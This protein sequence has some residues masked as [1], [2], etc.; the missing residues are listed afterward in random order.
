MGSPNAEAYL[1]SPAVVAAS[2]IAGKICGPD[3][4]DLKNLPGRNDLKFSIAINSPMTS[5]PPPP[6]PSSES[7]SESESKN[8]D[9]DLLLPGF[10]K[11]FSGPL[12]FAPQ[13]NLN[14]DGIYPGKYTYQDDIT[15]TKQSEVVMENYDPNFSKTVSKLREEYSL[16]FYDDSKTLTTSNDSKVG[17]SSSSNGNEERKGI[18]LI[19]GYNFGTGSSR[20]QAATALKYSGIPLVISGSFGDIFKRNSINNGLICLECPELIEDLTK[21]LGRDGKRNNGGKE[22][23]EISVL[24][25]GGKAEINVRSKD[26]HLVIRRKD[27][28]EKIYTTRPAGIGKSVQDIFTAGGLEAWVKKRLD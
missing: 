15:P 10:P 11:S 4:L 7:E 18:I 25:D 17:T 14:T 9:Q 5:A 22:Q 26:G 16:P 24:L 20:E 28:S 1:A 6:P 8:Q 2:A 23:G 21:E 13:D 12:I 3:D 19:G 27:G